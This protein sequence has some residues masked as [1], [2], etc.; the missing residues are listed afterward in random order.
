MAEYVLGIDVGTTSVKVILV[1]SEGSIVEE[2]N[3]AHDLMSYFPNW[4]EENATIWWSNV[5]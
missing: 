5:V 3:E 2:A 4:A 1:S